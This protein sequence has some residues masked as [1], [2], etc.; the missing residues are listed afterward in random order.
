MNYGELTMAGGEQILVRRCGY[1]L[2][3][4]LLVAA[5]LFSGVATADTMYKYR[6]ENGEW[7]F[8]DRPPADGQQAETRSIRARLERGGLSVT[9]L[10]DGNGLVFTARNRYHAPMEVAINFESI[11]GVDFPDP[12]Q[13]LRWLIP[14]RSE[15][16]LLELASLGQPEVPAAEYGYVYLPGDPAAQPDDSADYRVPFSVGASYPITQTFPDSVTHLTRDS[17]YAVDIAMPV[18]TDI[19]AARDG[20]VFDVAS[21]N[22]KGG[23]DADQYADLANLVRIL[24]DDGT[25]AVYAHLN[26]NTI[27]V[28]PGDRVLAGQYIADSGNTGFSSGPHLHFAVQRNM[29]LRVDSLPVAFRGPNAARVVPSSGKQLTAHP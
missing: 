20:I 17:M 14:A 13:A 15:L 5:L 11:V 23:A 25:Y 12:D 10:F 6:G 22:F 4:A 7:I 21:T 24:H 3:A 16:V 27:R 2:R 19:V 8:S 1:R 9:H 26:W 18:G 29:G 28:R